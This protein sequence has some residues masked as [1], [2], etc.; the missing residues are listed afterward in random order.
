M[1]YTKV[2]GIGFDYGNT[3]VNDPFDKVMKLK[4]N[5][6]IRIM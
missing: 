5:D 6:F 2:Q 1:A 3:L 4:A